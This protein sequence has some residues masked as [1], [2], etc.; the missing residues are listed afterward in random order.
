[1]RFVASSSF[2]LNTG[3]VLQ[4][5]T[6]LD[7][8]ATVTGVFGKDLVLIGGVGLLDFPMNKGMPFSRVVIEVKAAI[9]LEN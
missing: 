7:Y 4:S 8:W 3:D 9:D 5:E 2:D 6:L 1:M